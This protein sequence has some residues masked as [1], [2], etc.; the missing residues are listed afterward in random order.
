MAVLTSTMFNT[1]SKT[2]PHV[3]FTILQD[4]VDQWILNGPEPPSMADSSTPGLSYSEQSPDLQESI[5]IAIADQTKI[6]WDN[7]LTGIL[8]NSWLA[9]ARHSNHPSWE[10]ERRLQTAIKGLHK[11][12]ASLWKGRNTQLHGPSEQ[13]AT[14]IYTAE[15]AT[16]RYYHSRPHLLGMTDRHSCDKPLLS[17]LRGSPAT[18]RRWLMRVRLARADYIKDGRLQT[19][20]T[21]YF[22]PTEGQP[23]K[24]AH[25]RARTSKET[26]AMK[27]GQYISN[28]TNQDS[29]P[30][31]R[32]RQATNTNTHPKHSRRQVTIQ[33]MITRFYPS[34]RPPDPIINDKT[35]EPPFQIP[36]M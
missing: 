31:H 25:A 26:A 8:A 18:R 23:P 13:E 30:L 10:A 1:K 33:S 11:R 7:A 5:S 15:S 32:S 29:L 19:Q 17:I 27:T 21:S 3:F 4:C 16:I 14:R 20:I 2:T 9:V 36:R 24:N 28:N 6:G 22:Q 34:A 12:T 35:F